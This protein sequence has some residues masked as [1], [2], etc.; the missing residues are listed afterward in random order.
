MPGEP[1]GLRSDQAA[2]RRPSGELVAARE[3]ELAEHRGD[4]GFDGLHGDGE[5]PRDL[6]VSVAAGDVPEHL[7]I[8]GR[9]LV[10]LG[11]RRLRHRN[12]P[13]ERVQHEARESGGED[14]VAAVHALDRA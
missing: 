1:R 5:L 3:L 11:M 4:V 6:L 10:Q 9:E 14:G 2:I 7:A 12:T 13:Y 8:A